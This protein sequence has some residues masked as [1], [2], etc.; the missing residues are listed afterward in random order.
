M[1]SEIRPPENDLARFRRV[2]TSMKECKDNYQLPRPLLEKEWRIVARR[3]HPILTDEERSEVSEIGRNYLNIVKTDAA[4]Q[5]RKYLE[6]EYIPAFQPDLGE[7]DQTWLKAEVKELCLKLLSP[8]S[9]YPKLPQQAPDAFA[10][11]LC[12]RMKKLAS[13]KLWGIPL[14]ELAYPH[15]LLKKVL[16][17]AESQGRDR[18]F[19]V[20]DYESQ[21]LPA[22]RNIFRSGV[23]KRVYDAKVYPKLKGL[24]DKKGITGDHQQQVYE[25]TRE[26]FNYIFDKLDDPNKAAKEL[27]KE[28]DEHIYL[29]RDLANN[30]VP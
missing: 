17:L 10:S 20:K 24:I 7:R 8:D 13:L 1:P 22:M 2:H 16:D 3:V 28:L 29:V 4:D 25:R 27:L 12:K 19:R 9:P 26:R 23:E 5:V 21:V 11:D 14:G 6:E 15:V 18:P 30:R